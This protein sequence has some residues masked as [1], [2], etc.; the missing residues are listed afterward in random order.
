MRRADRRRV[1]AAGS[2][3]RSSARTVF[4]LPAPARFPAPPVGARERG[5]GRARRTR[6]V[7]RRPD[8]RRRSC[9]AASSCRPRSPQPAPASRRAPRSGLRP[10]PPAA[11]RGARRADRRSA[12][13]SCRH[14]AEIGFHHL[15]VVQNRA[16]R[17]VGD[18]ASGIHADQPLG[19][20]QQHM[21]DVF[22]PDD[23][24]VAPAQLANRGDQFARL[25]VGQAAADLVEKQQFGRGSQRA[26]VR[27]ACGR[28]GRAFPRAGCTRTTCRTA[29]ANRGCGRTLRRARTQRP[30]RRPA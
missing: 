10:A 6:R 16:R 29:A 18:D 7:R 19:H 4:G 23:R 14:A 13:P 30:E 25:A 21:H 1:R 9:A 12:A 5:S 24:D 22:D 27:A 3:R 17:A 8:A 20:L 28:A 15:P 11:A 26:R 2:P